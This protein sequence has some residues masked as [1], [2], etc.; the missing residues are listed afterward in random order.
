MISVCSIHG[1]VWLDTMKNLIN[2]FLTRSDCFPSIYD[3]KITL[4]VGH[5]HRCAQERRVQKGFCS[6]ETGRVLPYGV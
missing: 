1:N 3:H 2:I 6:C 4:T 5:R